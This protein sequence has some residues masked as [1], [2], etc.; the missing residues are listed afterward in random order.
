MRHLDIQQGNLFDNAEIVFGSE[1]FDTVLEKGG[2]K[3]ERI[4]SHSHS[5]PADFWYDQNTAEWVA[6]LKGRAVVEFADGSR[7]D[8]AAGDYLYIAPHHRHRIAYTSP[9][10]VW[11]AIHIETN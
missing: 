1:K 3:I 9:Q 11:L 4:V 6:V 2:V 7:Q 8:M 5:S 10:T